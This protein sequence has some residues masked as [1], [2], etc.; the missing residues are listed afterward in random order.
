M[1]Q[2]TNPTIPTIENNHEVESIND[3][4][5]RFTEM[6]PVIKTFSNSS[7]SNLKKEAKEL[8]KKFQLKHEDALDQAARDK[9]F[10]SFNDFRKQFSYWQN[11]PT[12]FIYISKYATV[13]HTKEV[14]NRRPEDDQSKSIKEL[15]DENTDFTV[16]KWVNESE[17]FNKSNEPVILLDD[18]RLGIKLLT[19]EEKDE[20]ISSLKNNTSYEFS[21][22]KRDEG[23]LFKF[24]YFKLDPIEKDNIKHDLEESS[25][26]YDY[27][28]SEM[29]VETKITEYIDDHF[30]AYLTTEIYTQDTFEYKS[31][32]VEPDAYIVNGKYYNAVGLHDAM[33][34]QFGPLFHSDY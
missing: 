29:D 9:G 1:S 2:F 4:F 31:F 32:N 33:P 19:V 25:K 3:L 6:T 13:R 24:L 26:K 22:I 11:L 7:E 14:Y 15:M 23:F 27:S 16:S 12:V 5:K 34:D 30:R 21:S 18:H 10:K 17:S 20:F 28:F 8:K